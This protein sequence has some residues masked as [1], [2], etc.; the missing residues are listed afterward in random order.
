MLDKDVIPSR[1]DEA[2][3]DPQEEAVG[4]NEAD[5]VRS[6]HSTRDPAD[7]AALSLVASAAFLETYAGILPGADIVAHCRLNNAPERFA[8]WAADPACVVT[9]AEHPQGA[10]PLGYTLLTPPDFPQPTGPDEI[11]LRRI[12]TLATIHGS[13]LGPALLARALAD[14]VA[15]GRRRMLLGTHPGNTRARRF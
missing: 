15:L 5:D 2:N 3:H 13:G 7:A 4:D 14:A 1:E 6:H 10:A 9:V 12:Y 11:E 8:A